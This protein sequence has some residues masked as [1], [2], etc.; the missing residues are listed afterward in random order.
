MART[1]FILLPASNNTTAIGG[2]ALYR[3]VDGG[4][5]TSIG[6]NS[7]SNNISGDS[8]TAIGT[9]ALQFNTASM[10]TATGASAFVSIL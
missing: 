5:N 7:L 6:I 2:Y 8:N 10:N 4:Y 9:R 3:N 1:L